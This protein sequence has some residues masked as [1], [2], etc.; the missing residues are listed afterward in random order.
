M[1]CRQP[2]GASADFLLVPSSTAAA[3]RSDPTCADFTDWDG[4]FSY[5][6]PTTPDVDPDLTL[7]GRPQGG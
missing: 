5:D 3:M 4:T 6:D 7:L 2:W 1:L